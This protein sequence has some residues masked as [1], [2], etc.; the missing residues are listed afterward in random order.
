MVKNS[1]QITNINNEQWFTYIQNNSIQNNSIQ[2]NLIQNI[3][4]LKIV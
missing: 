3:L 4:N 2:N 1:I